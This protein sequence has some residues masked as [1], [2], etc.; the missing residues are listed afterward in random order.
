M[1][2]TDPLVVLLA[3]AV[4]AMVAL[5]VIQVAPGLPSLLQTLRG[6]EVDP[7]VVG[8]VRGLAL[9]YLPI[10]VGALV[11]WVNGWTHPLLV[12]AVPGLIALVRLAESAMDRA[13]KP[14]QNMINPPPVAGGGSEELLDG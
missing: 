4:L 12:P 3:L 2:W 6:V 1:S 7:R 13:L 11:V 10:G 5:V 9:Y 8:I 14:Q